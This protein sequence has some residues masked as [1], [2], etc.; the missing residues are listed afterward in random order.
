[1]NPS[2]GFSQQNQQSS[3]KNDLDNESTY[4]ELQTVIESVY[5]HDN[6]YDE[7]TLQTAKTTNAMSEKKL[8][9]VC[10]STR[11]HG[12][13]V[14]SKKRG[15]SIFFA[16]AIVTVLEIANL[17]EMLNQTGYYSANQGIQSEITNLREM[18]NQT[19]NYSN[20]EIESLQLLL[21]NLR[22]MLNQTGDNFNHEI[23]SLQLEVANLR[24]TL[25]M[26]NQA[27]ESE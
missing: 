5:D 1:M 6:T 19:G 2:Y 26:D 23:R 22:E 7:L 14:N 24:A 27:Q 17:R 25:E 9:P 21:K 12:E 11:L 4:E 15:A 16:V 8:D 18:L 3:S 10:I 20:Q 13:Q